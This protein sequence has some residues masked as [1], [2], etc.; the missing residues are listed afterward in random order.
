MYLGVGCW[1]QIVRAYVVGTPVTPHVGTPGVEKA[2]GRVGRSPVS[3]RPPTTFIRQ[4]FEL[5]FC[6]VGLLVSYLVWGLL[7][8]RVM[9]YEYG[10]L[11]DTHGDVNERGK[12]FLWTGCQDRE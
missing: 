5:A 8:E 2:G 6:S 11:V 3:D 9:S 10:G 7:Q 1:G 12:W 4:F